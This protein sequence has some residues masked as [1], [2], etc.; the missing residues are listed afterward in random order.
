MKVCL[1]TGGTKG[2]GSAIVK[3]FVDS[4]YFVVFTYKT[5]IENANEIIEKYKDKVLAIKSDASDFDESEKVITE[6]IEKFGRVDVLVNNVGHAKDH[7][8]WSHNYEDM[9]YT[10]Q[11]TFFPAFNYIT[12]SV[13]IMKSQNYGR[14]INIGSINGIRGR[15]GSLGYASAKAALIGLTKS[16]AKEVG[17]FGITCNLIAPGYIETDGQK[18]TSQLIKKMVLEESAIKKLPKPDE[19]AQLVFFLGD[20]EPGNITGQVLQTDCGQYI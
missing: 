10:M 14:I 17:R 20:V 3:L 12:N 1:V 5:S 6:T 15:E 11:N 19:V 18:N 4:G 2:L 8:I 13:E 9:N 7:P 16:V